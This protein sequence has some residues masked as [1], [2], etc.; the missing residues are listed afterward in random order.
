M[1]GLAKPGEVQEPGRFTNGRMTG[2]QCAAMTIAA[3]WSVMPIFGTRIEN[4]GIPFAM[5]APYLNAADKGPW[6]HSGPQSKRRISGR[7]PADRAFVV[8]AIGT[9]MPAVLTLLA[10]SMDWLMVSLALA[11]PIATSWLWLATAKRLS[12]LFRGDDRPLT[13]RLSREDVLRLVQEA[14]RQKGLA[15]Q[16]RLTIVEQP[17]CPSA[18]VW[19]LR[20]TTVGSWWYAEV[21]DETGILR[22]LERQGLR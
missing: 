7:G 16:V 22:K 15:R 6:R 14:I 17:R 9:N 21:E 4:A 11:L 13:A 20:E 18:R 1:E 12:R 5:L 3:R 10:A 19:I 2:G 8:N